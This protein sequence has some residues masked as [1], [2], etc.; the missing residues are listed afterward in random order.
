MLYKVLSAVQDQPWQNGDKLSPKV[1]L[2]INHNGANIVA[3]YFT[4][5]TPES[6]VN[7][8]LDL[9]VEEKTTRDGQKKYFTAK[10]TRKSKPGGDKFQKSDITIRL[11]VLKAIGEG[12]DK[13]TALMNLG[14]PLQVADKLF[15]WVK[16]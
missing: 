3:G 15:E 4:E 14:D 10:D 7:K 8:E 5:E 1:K 6:L 12:I 11:E 9:L 16:K 2:T 13:W